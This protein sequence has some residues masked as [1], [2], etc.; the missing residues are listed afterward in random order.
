MLPPETPSTIRATKTQKILPAKASIAHPIVAPIWLMISTHLRP[1]RSDTLPQI[2]PDTN[3]HS[4]NV[5]NRMPTTKG[6]APKCVT[7]Y[8]ITGN[9]MLKPR[10][11]MNVMPRIGT[12]LRII[13]EILRA[14]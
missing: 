11:S 10:M 7:K 8:G 3:W 1:M 14:G 4:E 12:S 9:S 2:G 13:A 5:E 6:L